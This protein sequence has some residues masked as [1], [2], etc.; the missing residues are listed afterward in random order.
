MIASLDVNPQPRSAAD[1]FV[2]IEIKNRDRE[3][4]RIRKR[5]IRRRVVNVN[6]LGVEG[7]TRISL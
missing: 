6:Y 2:A 4:Y 7:I 3:A 5:I 1:S